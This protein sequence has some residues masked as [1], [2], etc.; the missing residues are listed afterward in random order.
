MRRPLLSAVISTTGV[1]PLR[2]SLRSAN[3]RIDQEGA[4]HF[5]AAS[6]FSSSSI[7]NNDLRMPN[8]PVP[9]LNIS[10]S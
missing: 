6:Y 2:D 3:N 9:M 10:S 8:A 4:R 7:C 5:A 1:T